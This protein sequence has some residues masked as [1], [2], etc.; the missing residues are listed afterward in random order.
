MWLGIF[1][2]VGASS[3][4]LLVVDQKVTAM[5]VNSSFA[6]PVSIALMTSSFW[7]TLLLLR[8]IDRAEISSSFG[9]PNNT[10]PNSEMIDAMQ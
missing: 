3:F 10:I 5:L 9:P 8:H 2:R 7:A 1:A 4:I 6:F